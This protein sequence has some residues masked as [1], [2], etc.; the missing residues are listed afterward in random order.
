[1]LKTTTS[2]RVSSA[3]ACALSLI[4][5]GASIGM[6]PAALFRQ[7]YVVRYRQITPPEFELPSGATRIA[8]L[9][10]QGP[11]GRKVSDEMVN[12]IVRATEW[13][14]KLPWDE[15]ADPA[16]IEVIERSRLD[17]VLNEQ[18]LAESG[19]VG[20]QDAARLGG[21][22]GVTYILVGST[23]KVVDDTSE[24]KRE[25]YIE[26]DTKYPVDVPYYTRVARMNASVRVIDVA[27]GRVVQTYSKTAEDRQVENDFGKLRS[28]EIMLSEAAKKL[29]PMLVAPLVMTSQDWYVELR[30]E[31]EWKEILQTAHSGDYDAA[32]ASFEALRAND[33]Y[34]AE[35]IFN[36]AALNE[37][38]GDYEKALEMYKAGNQ[39]DPKDK[40]VKASVQR[41]EGL[42]AHREML[43]ARGYG[44]R[45]RRFDVAEVETAKAEADKTEVEVARKGTPLYASADD[46]SSTLAPLPKGMRFEVLETKSSGGKTYYRVKTFDGKEGWLSQKD[47]TLR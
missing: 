38:I 46:G 14:E 25:Y 29:G 13:A 20:D 11:H 21:L 23:E 19:L 10:L 16:V 4:V 26:S 37:A 36:L 44:L 32:W 18:H 17:Q 45:S 3:W 24:V 41:M 40:V 39:I 28:P 7:D 47:V 1:M 33:P 42:I 30:Y 9:D 12:A 27:T 8:V 43:K 2:R 6:V 31:K 22:L 35:L 34:N 15:A 5:A